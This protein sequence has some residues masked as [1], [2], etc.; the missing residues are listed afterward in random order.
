MYLIASTIF[1]GAFLVQTLAANS[2]WDK[3]IDK[4]RSNNLTNIKPVEHMDAVGLETDGSFNKKMHK[5]LFLG[6]HETIEDQ[7]NTDKI[8]KSL[9]IIFKE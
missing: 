5:E 1:R 7:Y 9:K 2:K 3:I 4:L 8:I 6:D